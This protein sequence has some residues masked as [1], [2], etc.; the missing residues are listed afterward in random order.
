MQKSE[1]EQAVEELADTLKRV[2]ANNAE[3]MKKIAEA[4]NR[5]KTGLADF[6]YYEQVSKGRKQKAQ[7]VIDKENY[8]RKLNYKADKH[9]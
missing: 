4:T 6:K 2:L 3:A 8:Q 5:L 7:S 1:Y 9:K